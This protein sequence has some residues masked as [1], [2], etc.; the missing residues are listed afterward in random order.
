MNRT[1]IPIEI[2]Q[3]TSLAALVSA[4][5]RKAIETDTWEDFLPTERHLGEMFQVSR[6]TL[7]VA[8]H[9]LAKEGLIEIKPGRGSRLLKRSVHKSTAKNRLVAVITLQPVFDLGLTYQGVSEM[10]SH[11]AKL[12]FATEVVHCQAQ[13]A[14]A[15]RYVANYL[16]RNRVFCCVLLSV[17]ERLQRW[18]STHSI[19]ALVLGSCHPSV[20]LPSLDF[21]NRSVCRHA[22]GIFVQRGHRRLAMLSPDSGLAGDLVGEQGF[23]EALNE[24]KSLAR[25]DCRIVHHDSTATSITNRL[26]AMLRSAAPPTG[27]LIA[28]TDEA[29]IVMMYLLK[30]G[31]PVPDKI[32]LISRDHHRIFDI[33]SPAIA[34][35]KPEPGIFEHRLSRLMLQMVSQGYLATEPTLILPKFFAGGTIKTLA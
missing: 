13:G 15:E 23:L 19:P 21:D 14:A 31:L 7:R 17:S 28:N 32:S 3:R 10:R 26:D 18:F 1:R 11:L 6:P 25:S 24:H 33:L 12:G 9:L 22:T 2:P 5:I 34:H 27:L 4:S 29:F 20:K 30:R 35:Y 8:L 16:Q